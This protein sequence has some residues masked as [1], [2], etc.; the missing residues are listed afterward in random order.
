MIPKIIHQ[1]APLDK[2]RWHGSWARCQASVLQN[3]HGFEY[4]LWSD[5]DLETLVREKY[6]WFLSFYKNYPQHIMRVDAARYMVL[7][8]YGG[9]YIDMDFEVVRPFFHLLPQD[10]VS[11]V[12]SCYQETETIQ[13][14]LM[15]SPPKHMFWNEVM[16]EM[17]ATF[18]I[19][20][21]SV[22]DATGPRMLDRVVEYH[23]KCVHVLPSKF[24]NPHPQSPTTSDFLY[25]KH[26]Y[27]AVWR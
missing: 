24:F 4:R 3:F 25:T 8:T 13:N 26:H 1:T 22:L 12:E 5:E 9:V 17:F 6:P 16:R 10:K 14:S 21:E 19:Y 11:L 20:Q 7:D 15:A 23:P 27:S 18:P 2:S